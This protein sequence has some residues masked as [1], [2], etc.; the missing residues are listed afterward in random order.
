MA[1]I[2]VKLVYNVAK[3][4]GPKVIKFVLENKELVDKA[5]PYF[6]KGK[7]KIKELQAIK[8]EKKVEKEENTFDQFR[9]INI[10]DYKKN[11]LS[12][13]NSLSRIQL[14][15]HKHEIDTFI[16]QISHQEKQELAIKKPIYSKSIKEWNSL[17][18]QIENQIAVMDYHEYLNIYNNHEYVSTYFEG[19][20]RKVL[21]FKKVIEEESNEALYNFIHVQTNRDL[22]TIAQD[23]S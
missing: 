1:K 16:S 13:L 11:D 20:E 4:H 10:K 7:E 18:V 12:N 9:K 6:E 23:F 8:Q 14:I 17:L 2:P 3:D 22:A 5:V 21:S 15:K 19:F